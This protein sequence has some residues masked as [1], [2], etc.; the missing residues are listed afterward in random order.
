MLAPP[1]VHSSVHL[2]VALFKSFQVIFAKPRSTLI[3]LWEEQL[4]FSGRSWL[5]SGHFGFLMRDSS[6]E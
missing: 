1:S 3:L 6:G 2:L 5:I 4:Q